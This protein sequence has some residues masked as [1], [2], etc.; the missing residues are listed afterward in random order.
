MHWM[1][2]PESGKPWVTAEAIV[3]SFDLDR[4]KVIE[5]SPEALASFEDQVLA[6]L[7]L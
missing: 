3:I 5:I 7:C 6:G 1:L 2:D 4:R